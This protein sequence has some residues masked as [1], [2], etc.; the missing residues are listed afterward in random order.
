MARFLSLLAM[1][2]VGAVGIL[3]AASNRMVI[4]LT[5]WPLP[6]TLPAPVYAV[7]LGGIAFGVLW[8]GAIGWLSSLRARRRARLETKRADHLEQ[9]IGVLRE[10]IEALERRTLIP[11]DN[12]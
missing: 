8:G 9:D 10:K 11:N 3:F 5:V 12:P 2:L 4:D 1:I 6:F 7:V